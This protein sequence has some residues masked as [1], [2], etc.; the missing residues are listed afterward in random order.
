[1]SFVLSRKGKGRMIRLCQV[2]IKTLRLRLYGMRRAQGHGP[3]E[4]VAGRGRKK[5]HV[6]SLRRLAASRQQFDLVSSGTGGRVWRS[7]GKETHAF[8][9]SLL[10]ADTVA[11]R[12][13]KASGLRCQRGNPRARPDHTSAVTWGVRRWSEERTTKGRSH[14]SWSGGKPHD[15]FFFFVF[16]S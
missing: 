16:L 14:D 7:A 1:V 10:S 12:P 4:P 3:T 2:G 5:R 8:H 9:P 13:R 6:G 11:V 15:E